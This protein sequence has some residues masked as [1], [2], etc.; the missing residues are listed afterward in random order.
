MRAWKLVQRKKE[1]KKVGSKLIVGLFKKAQISTL[2]RD[3]IRLPLTTIDENLRLSYQQYC[4]YKKQ[5]NRSRKKWLQAL[6]ESRATAEGLTKDDS[7]PSHE[8][9]K[10]TAKHIWMWVQIK[11]TRLMYR[12]IHQAVGKGRMQGV[13][14]VIAPD[15]AGNWNK[16]AWAWRDF[17]KLWLLNIR[18]NITK[19]KELRRWGHRWYTWWAT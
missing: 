7:H 1:G 6:V 16:T 17:F 3:A 11:G 18:Q 4:N 2:C 9:D 19:R 15:K 14:M 5:A 12:C 8:H 10:A 13:S